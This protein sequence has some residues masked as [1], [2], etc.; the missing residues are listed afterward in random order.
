[1]LSNVLFIGW[2]QQLPRNDS[3]PV[4]P[5][6]GSTLRRL[7]ILVPTHK[8]EVLLLFLLRWLPSYCG[9]FYFC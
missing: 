1:V 9:A 2:A 3:M 7:P 8:L 6:N 5:N 4:S